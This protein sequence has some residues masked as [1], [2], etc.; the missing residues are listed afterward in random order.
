MKQKVEKQFWFLK[1]RKDV[2]LFRTGNEG[3][4]FGGAVFF[5]IGF[6]QLQQRKENDFLII[7]ALNA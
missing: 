7:Q 1:H 2:F 5:V 6:V 3:L 4:T